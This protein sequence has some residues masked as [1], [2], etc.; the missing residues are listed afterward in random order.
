MGYPVGPTATDSVVSTGFTLN[1][2]VGVFV[3]WT[4]VPML[5]ALFAVVE[6]AY[7]LLA[8]CVCALERVPFVLPPPPQAATAHELRTTTGM[9]CITLSALI[10][11]ILLLL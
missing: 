11:D 1:A 8:G 10:R 5:T 3:T 9:P 7:P 2:F 6:L 4:P